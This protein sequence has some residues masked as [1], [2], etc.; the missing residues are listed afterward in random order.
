VSW[1]STSGLAMIGAVLFCCV[2]VRSYLLLVVA[3]R[4]LFRALSPELGF[5]FLFALSSDLLSAILCSVQE[6]SL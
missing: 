4:A 3:N 2:V 6:Q 5:L 1:R